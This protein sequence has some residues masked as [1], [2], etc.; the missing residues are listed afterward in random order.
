MAKKKKEMVRVKALTYIIYD[1]EYK[2]GEE[3]E[4]E[5]EYAEGLVKNKSAEI[6]EEVEEI[7]EDDQEGDP[8]EGGE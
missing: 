1:K 4:I 7:E 3:F 6:L 2:K 5:K 8:P